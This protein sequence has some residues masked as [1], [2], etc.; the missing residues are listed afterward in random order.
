MILVHHI[1]RLQD[2]HSAIYSLGRAR[3]PTVPIPLWQDLI[4]LK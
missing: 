4:L 2:V 1:Q 3:H